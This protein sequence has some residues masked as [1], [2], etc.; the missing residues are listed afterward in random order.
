MRITPIFQKY[1]KK[2]VFGVT[3]LYV[4]YILDIKFFLFTLEWLDFYS[5][6]EGFPYSGGLF[7]NLIQINN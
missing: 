6:R 5:I 3:N 2:L 4:S 7:L 1:K